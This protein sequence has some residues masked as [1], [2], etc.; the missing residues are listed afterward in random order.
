[1]DPMP[2]RSSQAFSSMY[3]DESDHEGDRDSAD[4]TAHEISAFLERDLASSAVDEEDFAGRSERPDVADELQQ[5]SPLIVDAS[6]QAFTCSSTRLLDDLAPKGSPTPALSAP[7]SPSP[8]IEP[9]Q[10]AAEP[11]ASKVDAPMR[12]STP[13]PANEVPS[14]PVAAPGQAQ[15]MAQAEGSPRSR[16]PSQRLALLLPETTTSPSRPEENAS[17]APRQVT[18]KANQVPMTAPVTGRPSSPEQQFVPELDAGKAEAP[19]SETDSRRVA[20]EDPRAAV[21]AAV[22]ATSVAAENDPSGAQ[23]GQITAESA[24]ADQQPQVDDDDTYYAPLEDKDMCFADASG[25]GAQSIAG[26]GGV[27]REDLSAN[28]PFH[29]A[30]IA[31]G[32]DFASAFHYQVRRCGLP[33]CV[34][35]VIDIL[36][37]RTCI[38]QGGNLVQEASTHT[39]IENLFVSGPTAP[40][41]LD[42]ITD[43]GAL[44]ALAALRS[45]PAL[46]P[47]HETSLSQPDASKRNTPRRA[48]K[49]S[50]SGQQR[51]NGTGTPIKSATA[52]TAP[53]SGRSPSKRRRKP[54][55]DFILE[56]Y[57]VKSPKS[58]QKRGSPEKRS[59]GAPDALIAGTSTMTRTGGGPSD[60]PVAS[61]S[62]VTLD[63]APAGLSSPTAPRASLLGSHTRASASNA[64]TDPPAAVTTPAAV[65]VVA[66]PTVCDVIEAS[67]ATHDYESDSDD[68]LAA[69]PPRAKSRVSNAYPKQ[70]TKSS[71]RL[72]DTSSQSP[73]GNGSEDEAE[74]RAIAQ[75]LLMRSRPRRGSPELD[76]QGSR[77]MPPAKRWFSQGTREDDP[78]SKRPRVKP[79]ADLHRRPSLAGKGQRGH[80]LD[81]L[82]RER[83]LLS[84]T[85]GYFLPRQPA[86][87]VVRGDLSGPVARS[88]PSTKRSREAQRVE[89]REGHT[90][91]KRRHSDLS[92]RTLDGVSAEGRNQERRSSVP[93]HPEARKDGSGPPTE[94]RQSEAGPPPHSVEPAVSPD[95]RSNDRP[96]RPSPSSLGDDADADDLDAEDDEP[97]QAADEELEEPVEVKTPARPRKRPKKR[98]PLNMPRYKGRKR[99]TPKQAR[100]RSPTPEDTASPEPTPRQQQQAGQASAKRKQ[101][102]SGGVPHGSSKRARQ[103]YDEDEWEG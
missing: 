70:L 29:L 96:L 71:R 88:T 40:D 21:E 56:I 18:P 36:H 12:S 99:A 33:S 54:V 67:P 83:A 74:S 47:G 49:T 11:L 52:A 85:P 58:R 66:P 103:A 16:S 35:L 73:G 14:A 62:K 102:I 60:A 44:E 13:V 61:T 64:V 7:R 27:K 43:R 37:T 9:N 82:D 4:A 57:P 55:D 8:A 17:E 2:L 72:P 48:P 80:L 24:V 6:V 28:E 23:D 20:E 19:V 1:M 69:P 53:S 30:A 50:A 78:V 22:V 45:S 15:Q 42:D 91:P 101:K 10:E 89:V 95:G 77:P 92:G 84:G 32:P 100:P 90:P 97:P 93:G 41:N 81:A 79:S 87:S 34:V 75:T 38:L 94:R 86:Y 46:S 25:S 63:L 26:P 68:P 65:H 76:A 5:A 3:S 31:S 98:K 59:E 51:R 39:P